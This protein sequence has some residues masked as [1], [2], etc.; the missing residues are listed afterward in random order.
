LGGIQS[1]PGLHSTFQD[2][3]G[4]T[5]KLKKKKKTQNNKNNFY[6]EPGNVEEVGRNRL[7]DTE[8]QSDNL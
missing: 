8:S 6:K 5:E 2:S 1:Q 7:T 4:Y 3:Q